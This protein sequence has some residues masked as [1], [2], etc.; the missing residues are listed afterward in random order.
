[1]TDG[2]ARPRATRIESQICEGPVCTTGAAAAI[3]GC[4]QRTVIRLCDSGAIACR[5]LRAYREV[6]V[7][8]LPRYARESARRSRAHD[9]QAHVTE[10][11]EI[12]DRRACEWCT[13]ADAREA[14][15]AEA[16]DDLADTLTTGQA[17]R[18]IG[19][20]SRTVAA[21]CDAGTLPHWR[22]GAERRLRRDEVLAWLAA[23]RCTPTV[24]DRERRRAEAAAAA[25]E[26]AR[27]AGQPDWR[28]LARQLAGWC[29]AD[30]QRRHRVARHAMV[31]AGDLDGW[32]VGWGI[33]G[34]EAVAR[35]ATAWQAMTAGRR[36]TRG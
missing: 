19:T 26:A 21:M 20:S 22:I 36:P 10:W 16:L 4:G 32:L 17:A 24:A 35:I 15:R 2:P 9:D 12:V 30:P 28:T 14:A 11:V 8:D 25:D 18:L 33:P 34:P 31:A 23:R 29:D 13:M 27:L 7:L 6:F 3:L 5:R 1:M